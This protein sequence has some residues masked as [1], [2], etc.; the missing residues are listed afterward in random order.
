MRNAGGDRRFKLYV[1]AGHR[2]QPLPLRCGRS[3]A[4]YELAYETYG[5]LNADRS[6]AVLV[7]HAL[8]ASH[9]VAGTYA[10]APENLGWWA[11]EQPNTR[12]LVSAPTSGDLK[13]T[14]FEGDSG[15]LKVIPPE[16][17]AKYNSSLHEIT[18]I[19]GSLIK[20]I[21]ASEPERFR[22]PQFHGG[23]LD[24]LA[25][26]EYLRESWDMIQFGIRLGTRTKLIASTTPKPK[27]VV[28]E[29]IDREGDDVAIGRAHAVRRA[30]RAHRGDLVAGA[31]G[32]AG[33][34]VPDARSV[35]QKTIAG[36]TAHGH[37]SRTHRAAKHRKSLVKDRHALGRLSQ[38][39]VTL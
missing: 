10:D 8:N 3:L 7:C 34:L 33:Q 5:T 37:T 27:E 15:L 16:L 6:N 2:G 9:H 14:C 25:A 11:W 4:D 12:W 13:S 36:L 26:W 22:G 24:E 32:P 1:P 21:P 30:Q 31:Q 38:C 39:V 17:V 19:N 28:L 35:R 23:W 20:G 29:L 18:L